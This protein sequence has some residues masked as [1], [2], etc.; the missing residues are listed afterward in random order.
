M[1][2]IDGKATAAA[3]KQEIAE[4]VKQMVLARVPFKECMIVDTAGLSTMYA[5]DGGVIVVY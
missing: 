4:E 3:I 5:S 1:E 2:L